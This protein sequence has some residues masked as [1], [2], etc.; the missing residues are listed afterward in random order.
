MAERRENE[1][2][3][4][5][6]EGLRVTGGDP[7]LLDDLIEIFLETT[8]PQLAAIRGAVGIGDSRTIAAEAHSIKGAAGALGARVIQRCAVEIERLARGGEIEGISKRVDE[9]EGLLENL[10]R[11]HRQYP[12]RTSH[13]FSKRKV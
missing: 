12:A 3:I 2:I 10:D 1:L 13:R 7:R 5:R 4:D 11:E 6:S 9:L 8:G